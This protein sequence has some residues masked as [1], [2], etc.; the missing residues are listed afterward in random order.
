MSLVKAA[1]LSSFFPGYFFRDLDSPGR[2]NKLGPVESLRI[3][4]SASRD[5]RSVRQMSGKLGW[6]NRVSVDDRGLNLG[7]VTAY[8]K[9]SMPRIGAERI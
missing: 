8:A 9:D 3:S 5:C 4:D 6:E 1:P 2:L 7:D